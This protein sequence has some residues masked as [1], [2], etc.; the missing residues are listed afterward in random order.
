LRSISDAVVTTDRA[1]R[2]VMMNPVAAQ[3]SEVSQSEAIGK[4]VDSVFVLK[5]EGGGS[6]EADIFPLGGGAMASLKPLSMSTP[7]GVERYVQK[8]SAPIHDG[9]GSTVGEVI[10][11]RDVTQ[12]RK[13]EEELLRASKLESL[14]LLAG[15]IAHD[16]NNVLTGIVG[17]L[18]LLG[19]TPGLP[20]EVAERLGLLEKTAYKARQ[21]TM[22]LLTFAK[23]GSPIKQT[24][25]VAEVVRESAEFALRGANIRAEFSFPADL[26][27]VEI[28]TGQMSQVVQNLVINSKQAMPGGGVIAISA[29]N[30]PLA[31]GTTLPLPP[32]DYVRISVRD[33]GCGIKREHLDRIFDPYF[34][35]KA[36][37]T[38]LGLATVYSIMKRHE[39]LI[40]VES[41]QGHGSEFRLYLPASRAR[42][43]PARA[44]SA[45][46]L[47]C[48]GRVL[49]MDDEQPIRQLLTQI[50]AHFGCSCTAV[51]DGAAA[52]REYER[53]R[54]AGE[55]YDC[56]IMD[57][58]VPGGMGGA[59]AIEHLLRVDPGVQAI[60][61]SGYSN[62]PVMSDYREHGFVA[63]IEK[64]YRLHEMGAVLA[65]VLEK[66]PVVAP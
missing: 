8:R 38:G 25:S 18:S 6:L 39:G 42:V 19:E 34:T 49:A 60:V 15:G 40:T 11:Y 46:K 47:A 31:A 22:Q 9:A 48:S 52:I 2:I 12:E 64:P 3:M 33:T 32:G 61:S 29:E 44:E 58:T 14:G 66:R 28:D 62:D 30:H 16:F 5:E 65:Q 4:P 36:G 53:A 13:F 23:G 10:V 37:G 51:P 21:L 56:L 27:P 7:G 20:A 24:A 54:G 41:E 50:L 1:G 57:L 43:K 63:R 55:P 59:E 45:R 35:T 17:N 26:A